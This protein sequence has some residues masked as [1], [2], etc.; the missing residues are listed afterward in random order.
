MGE[1]EYLAIGYVF[2]ML[3]IVWE[4][5][6]S[7]W[8]ADGRYRLVESVGNIGHGAVYQVFD[9]FT[10]ALVMVPFVLVSESFA[11]RALPLDAWWAWLIAVV[12][13]DFVNYWQHR[14]GHEI[15][16]MW[17][18][19]GVH[20]AAEDYNLAAALRQPLLSHLYSWVYR[21]PLALFVPIP[22]FVGVVVFD[23]LYQ[24]VQHTR[25]VGTLGPLEWVMN[26]P[27]H[28]RVHHGRNAKYLDKNYGGIFIVWDRLFGTFQIEEEEPDYGITE[29]LGTVDP[30]WGNLALWWRLAQAAGRARGW[31]HKLAIWWV[32]PGDIARLAPAEASDRTAATT[33]ATPVGSRVITSYVLAQALVALP[34]LPL[35]IYVGSTL[36]WSQQLAL[37]VFMVG[38]ASALVAVIE[39]RPWATGAELARVLVLAGGLVLA[40]PALL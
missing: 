20:H 35:L 33:T 6:V 27:S 34:L 15:N 30:I 12:A 26:T 28:H 37:S 31:R 22:M 16:W 8:R 40:V 5:G 18:V 23:F 1:L 38:T 24:F 7:I 32:G 19:H 14:H 17:A 36:S 10:K 29:P 9:Y 25:Y 11:I 21:L 3:L 39:G 13:F 2:F 4:A